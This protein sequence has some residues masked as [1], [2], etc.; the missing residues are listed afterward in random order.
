MTHAMPHAK[1]TS[2]PP[3]TSKA[4]LLGVALACYGAGL[5]LVTAILLFGAS[6]WDGLRRL[7]GCG[8]GLRSAPAQVVPPSPAGSFR[9]WHGPL[10]APVLFLIAA[11][12]SAP[13]SAAP[14]AS[15]GAVALVGV[16]VAIFAYQQA[17]R[18]GLEGT[19]RVVSLLAFGAM[20]LGAMS[21]D[22]FLRRGVA[23]T[24]FLGKNGVGT[25]LATALPLVQL[26]TV[27]L[28]DPVVAW[29]GMLVIVA[30]LFL[31]MS[32]GGW[33]GAAAGQAV[34]LL[35]AA[36]R[37]R[38]TAALLV[39]M[40]LVTAV[41]LGAYVLSTGGTARYLLL[42]RLDPFSSSK[43]ERILIWEASWRMFLDHPWRGVG[44]GAFGAAYPAYRLERASE[45]EM[46][47]AHNIVLNLLAEMGLAGFA[48]FVWLVGTWVRQ[49][50]GALRQG[51]RPERRDTL[52]AL[53]AA[54]TA[55]LVHQLFDGTFWSLHVGV[56]FWLL[57]A[58][59]L[60][61]AR[62]T[63]E[64]GDPAGGG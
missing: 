17:H 15:W 38:R 46:S 42:T 13:G 14:E 8:R 54:L 16:M 50:L 5:G 36:P 9:L 58:L 40:A 63:A 49:A 30:A 21:L 37:L 7:A 4:E 33:V 59:L 10:A 39:V 6:V 27:G 19:R 28:L 25:L 44:I 61:T 51:L 53:L 26:S 3:S 41:A 22:G 12:A 31:S 1:P 43:T 34:L 29:G 62:H 47:F 2:S 11:L 18:I 32:Q 52:A 45:K 55:M 48:A 60:E 20:L 64:E 23:E 24:P 57:G 56:G 35:F